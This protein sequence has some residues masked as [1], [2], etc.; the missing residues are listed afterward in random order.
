MR[1]TTEP[2]RVYIVALS[3]EHGPER[4]RAE[5]GCD[6]DGLSDPAFAV[7]SIGFNVATRSFSSHS[8]DAC[9]EEQATR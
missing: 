1:P 2:R 8:L 3:I 5:L 7:L 4:A 9:G 6:P